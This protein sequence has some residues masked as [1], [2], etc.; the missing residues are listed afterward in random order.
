MIPD[1]TIARLITYRR[2]LGPLTPD[3]T[4]SVYSHELASMAGVSAAQVRRDIMTLGY[5]G[6]PT[7]G[8]DVR[9]LMDS[10]SHCLDAP[11]GQ[12]AALVGVGNLGRAILAFFGG[13]N[14]NITISAAFDSDTSK[15]GRVIHGCRCYH[16]DDM[17]SV[18]ESQG[19]ELAAVAVPAATAQDVADRLVRSGIQGILNF[20]PA[21][22]RVP[23]DVYVEHMD[24]SVSM[25]KVAYFARQRNSAKVNSR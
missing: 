3:A 6:S 4:Q 9:D 21:A 10:I 8:Y 25:E 13:R 2:V 14:P 22:L 19:I 17:P 18:I 11:E 5:T 20:A 24:I 7:R 23:P 1:R 16:M 15:T 12:Q